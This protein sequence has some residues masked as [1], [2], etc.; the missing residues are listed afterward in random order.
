MADTA[1]V[2]YVRL[3]FPNTSQHRVVRS[4]HHVA[5]ITGK[6]FFQSVSNHHVAV[7]ACKAFTVLP[8]NLQSSRCSYRLQSLRSSSSQSPIITLQVS[9]AKPSQFFQ[10][11][12]NHHVAVIAGKAFAVLPVN[13]QSSRCSYRLQSL[14]SSSSQSPIITL[15]LSLAKPSQ[16]FQS[17]SNHHV[18][19]IA[20]K[21]YYTQFFQS[22]SNHHVAVI[23]CKAFAVLPVNLQSSRCS[24]RLQSL[25]SSSSQSPI[26][27]LQL[28]LATPT[29]HN[30]SSQSPIIT[31]Q[32]SLATPSQFF[33]SISNHHVAV[34]ACKAFAVLPVNLQSS[35]CSYRLQSLLYTVLPVNLQ[36]SRCRYRLQ[37]LRSSSSQSPIITLQLSLAKPTVHSSSSQ[38]PIITLQLSLAKP[39]VHSSSSQS[40]IITLQVSLAKPSQFFQSISNHHVAV[41]ACKAYCTQF[42]Q[43][44]S[45]HHV[46]V[47]ACKAYC[48]QFFQSISNHHVAV[49]ACKAYCTQFFQSISKLLQQAKQL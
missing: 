36:S 11:I 23:A 43:S 5:V 16:F 9:L 14:H 46:A 25:P 39:T 29:I 8:V 37:S 34:I 47:I 26:I 6:A 48:T 38:S 10:S 12:S 13:L 7:I 28:S 33:Q 19:V 30:S 49:I 35:R 41:I 15:Q 42:F 40:P 21:A 20:C 44:I 24:Y 45:N 2:E 3:S 1:N 31:L 4:N 32:L 27:T 17:I 22:I 18:A